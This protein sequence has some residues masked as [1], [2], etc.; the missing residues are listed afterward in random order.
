[1]SKYKEKPLYPV[2]LKTFSLHSRDSKVSVKDFAKPWSS[3]GSFSDFLDGLPGILGG[4]DFKQFL[5]ILSEA[6]K[7][8]KTR[9]FALGAHVTKVGLNPILIDLMQAG[10]ISALA[11]NGAGIIHDFEIALSGETSEDVELQIQAGDFGM[12]SETG[13]ILNECINSAADEDIGIGEAVGK[14]ICDS[15]YAYKELSLLG[16][17]YALDIP[18]TVHVGIGT[19]TIHFHPQVKGE[20]LGKSGLRDFF[21]F[22][23]LVK[24]LDGGGVFVNVGSAVILPEVFLK[25]VSFIRNQGGCLEDFSTAVFDFVHHYRPFHNVVKRPLKGRGK[26]LYFI[27]QHEILIPLLAAALK[28]LERETTD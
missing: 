21:L 25:A 10:W 11:F 24:K 4:R 5:E 28:S 13:E 17:A 12:A 23:E 8:K 3:G 14:K 2:N 1:M 15:K 27:G 19:D 6:K 18:V 9:I 26:G 7:R 20:A 22:C 16:S